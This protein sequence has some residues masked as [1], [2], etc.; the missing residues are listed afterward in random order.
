MNPKP[1]PP[2][3]DETPDL[4]AIIARAT[5][6]DPL[7]SD[8][9]EAAFHAIMQGYATP[10][11]IAALLVA[12]RTRRE[13]P[14]EVAGGVR[15]LRRAMIPVA[16][17]DPDNLV[18]T[19][20]TG[21]GALTTFNISTAAAFVA[22]GAGVRIAKH[23]NRSFSSRCGSADILEAL[24]VHIELTPDGMADVL[25]RAGIVFMFAPLLHPAMRHVAPVRREL[26]MPTIMNLLGPLTNPAGAR[27]QVVGVADPALLEL[28]AHALQQLGHL[29]ALVVHGEPG[30]DEISPIGTTKMVELRD[31]AVTTRTVDL[32]AHFDHRSLDPADLAGGDPA[33]NARLVMDVLKGR[34]PAAARA[35]V[36]LNAAAAIYVADRADTL[37]DG[38]TRAVES[39]DTGAAHDAFERLRIA[40]ATAE[41]VR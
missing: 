33:D 30:M 37:D 38:V 4:T 35:A 28:I 23:G 16:A 26:R 11:Q 18:D 6:P 25:E 8:V 10:V 17:A 29:R 15:A 36:V 21:G 2:P 31:G 24:G 1:V 32:H 39:I 12:L 7:D 19:C 27:R 14:A 41:R 20:G 40:A 13:G 22:A 34:A 3:E 5:H 9:A